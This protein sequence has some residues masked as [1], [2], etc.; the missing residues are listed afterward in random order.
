MVKKDLEQLHLAVSLPGLS[1][2]DDQYYTS[3]VFA[4]L[5]GGGMSSRLFQE[6]REKKGLAYTI[7]AF[8][9]NMVDGG[10]FG[11]YAGTDTSSAFE[12]IDLSITEM[13]KLADHV[14]SQ[15]VERALKR[16]CVLV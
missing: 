5:Y 4:T 13:E 9:S 12:V 10:T 2:F 16:K 14:T 6:I 8:S 3:E 15:E 11:I 1:F 7:S